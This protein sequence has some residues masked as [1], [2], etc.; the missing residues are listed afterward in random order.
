[1]NDEEV[2]RSE[3]RDAVETWEIEYGA[4]TEKVVQKLQSQ[5]ARF[6]SPAHKALF[7]DEV[8]TSIRKVLEQHQKQCSQTGSCPIE[9]NGNK[10]L[11][12]VKQE[13]A[14]L[15]QIIHENTTANAKRDTV[16]ISYSHLDKSYLNIIKRHFKPL[17]KH[18]EFWEDSKI[19]PGQKWEDEIK[20]AMSR[21]KVALLL[22]SADFFNSEFIT[23]KE[24][25]PLLE[26]AERD[27]ATILFLVL[28]PCMLDEYPQIKQYQG[29]NAPS[30]PFI[31][32]SEVDQEDLCVS[33]A[34]T[35]R[36][37]L[38]AN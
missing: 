4:H 1:M 38:L 18:I 7:L 17:E 13:L 16:F 15:P 36:N 5:L 31:R 22:V 21:A 24:I 33:L 14:Q 9:R 25:P 11:F 26:A 23:K 20:G 35:I 27:G 29:V 2:V 32:M 28:K 6:Y 37:R 12:F 8:N 10:T 19:V 3:A 34:T 30:N